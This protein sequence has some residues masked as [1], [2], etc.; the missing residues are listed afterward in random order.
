MDKLA[1]NLVSALEALPGVSLFSFVGKTLQ[2]K[3]SF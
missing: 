2:K 1:K 3:S